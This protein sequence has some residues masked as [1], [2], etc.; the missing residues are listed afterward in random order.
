MLT[1]QLVSKGITLL[2]NS[3][4]IRKASKQDYY[5]HLLYLEAPSLFAASNPFFLL[6]TMLYTLKVTNIWW[7]HILAYYIA[8]F[9]DVFVEKDSVSVAV[10]E[11]SRYVLTLVMI[12]LGIE[13]FIIARCVSVL[14][15]SVC[16]IFI[17]TLPNP[18]DKEKRNNKNIVTYILENAFLRYFLEFD[19]QIVYA[20]IL[21]YGKYP[22]YNHLR[23]LFPDLGSIAAGTVLM[24]PVLNRMISALAASLIFIVPFYVDS[25]MR[26]IPGPISDEGTL[27][28][29]L[30]WYSAVFGLT[31]VHQGDSFL[32]L[33]LQFLALA[34]KP[35]SLSLVMTQFIILVLT[36]RVKIEIIPTVLCIASA[37]L[38][39]WSK[40]NIEDD[41]KRLL[42][43]AG[44]G[45]IV[46]GVMGGKGLV[47]G[48]QD[49]LKKWKE[50][51]NRKRTDKLSTKED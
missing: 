7:P 14:L 24:I 42:V 46:V 18:I 39:I 32:R 36:M 41:I 51:R 20:A 26:L 37:A 9:T 33:P 28:L 43:C 8:L 13:A 35:S 27:P 15:S 10:G 2:L 12:P 11:V 3:L 38:G 49:L 31:L 44:N 30:S 22:K 17:A 19:D 45:A 47:E 34:I 29:L 40:T 25:A 50:R 1:V 16:S 4:I 5:T 6:L 48:L 21:H 23:S